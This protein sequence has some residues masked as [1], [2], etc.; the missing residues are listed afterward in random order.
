MSSPSRRAAA[1]LT[2][3][4][5]ATTVAIGLGACTGEQAPVSGTRGTVSADAARTVPTVADLA[6][7]AWAAARTDAVTRLLRDRVGA[8]DRG[9]EAGWLAPL[10]GASVTS[11]RTTQ[12]AVFAR[13]RAMQAG[14]LEVTGVREVTEPVAAP[15]GTQVEWDVRASFT[16]RLR[17]FDRGARTFDLDLTFRADPAHPGD[18][19][20]TASAPSD[21][22]QPWDLAGLV[23]R[24]SATALALVVGTP[25]RVAEV[26]ARA[27]T[28]ASR[29][30]AVWGDSRPAV[31]VSPAT[32]A[33]A[34]RLLG[35]S[36]DDLR[37]VAA[38]TDGPLTP[39]Q[40]AGADRIVLV[41]GA[42]TSL[43]PDGRDVVMTHELTHVTVRASTTRAVPVWLSEGF[44]EL[45]A[46]DPID[47]P[48][49]TVVAPALER[50]R[51]SGLPAALPADADFEP[52][53]Q[54]LAAAYGLSLLALRTLADRYGTQAVVRLYRAAAGGLVEP[55]D[56]VDDREGA[57]DDALRSTVGTTRAA[58]VQQWQ[59]R[60]R[61]LVR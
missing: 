60:L 5:C 55:T 28:A 29:V 26:V 46:Y 51:T 21:R 1:R 41:P 48:E 14:D 2:V 10:G 22:P 42:W 43:R 61:G 52:G 53:T 30:A 59:A 58:L 23:V 45:V 31:W 32:D 25:S 11:L 36:A 6:P 39:G 20:I 49:A 12:S 8:A 4:A 47:L 54:T 16:Y 40:P 57:V 44:A 38:A 19:A 24:R 15:R 34:A 35:R 3:V 50:V 17:G 56:R 27:R 33:D 9:D 13:M 7:Q 18:L 37:G